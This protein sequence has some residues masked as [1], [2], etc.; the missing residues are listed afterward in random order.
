MFH[1]IFLNRT[2]ALPGPLTSVQDTVGQ[3][4]L[5][6][7]W[8]R[9]G[10]SVGGTKGTH[11]TRRH[12]MIWDDNK[13]EDEIMTEFVP[14][15]GIE[16]NAS[17]VLTTPL[18]PPQ[19]TYSQTLTFNFKIAALQTCTYTFTMDWPEISPG[20]SQPKSVIP[21]QRSSTSKYTHTLVFPAERK[22]IGHHYFIPKRLCFHLDSAS[23]LYFS[24][25]LPN[26]H[27]QNHLVKA[28]HPVLSHLLLFSC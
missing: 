17:R 5:V 8:R 2:I 28:F 10:V 14:F 18:E 15:T 3:P 9:L 7:R 1:T 21:L 23:S 11:D 19:N 24:F 27:M 12:V 4:G 22:C 13:V 26:T 20:K 6:V 16:P 25:F